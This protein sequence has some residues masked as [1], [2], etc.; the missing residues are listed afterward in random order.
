MRRARYLLLGRLLR[1]KPGYWLY[2]T[3]ASMAWRCYKRLSGRQPEV[4]YRA[5]L[6]RGERL[7][8]LTAKPLPK[9]FQ[10]RRWRRRIAAATLAEL[11]ARS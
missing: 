2:F 3:L 10:K 1:A 7:D 4:V 11:R 9:R 6:R 8:L 5:D